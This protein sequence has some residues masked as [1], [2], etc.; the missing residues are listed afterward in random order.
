MRPFLL[1]F[2]AAALLAPSSAFPH[3][4]D[5]SAPPLKDL[6]EKARQTGKPVLLD[7]STIW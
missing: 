6:L 7:F 3:G 2:A 1:S 4:F 5:K